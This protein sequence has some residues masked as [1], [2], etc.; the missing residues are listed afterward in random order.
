MLWC[1]Q[2]PYNDINDS[3]FGLMMAVTRG[4]RPPFD[5]NHRWPRGVVSLIQSLWAH[6]PFDRPSFEQLQQTGMLTF[7]S[8]FLQE[9]SEEESFTESDLDLEL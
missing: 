7:D 1:G 8:L 5:P 6:A 3:L 9:S 4:T 2:Q